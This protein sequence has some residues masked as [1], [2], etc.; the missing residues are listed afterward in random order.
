MFDEK[1]YK[2]MFSQ[3]TASDTTRRRIQNMEQE[4]MKR[5]IYPVR[6]LAGILLAVALL[7]TLSITA[8]AAV[9]GADWFEKFFRESSGNELSDSQI[10]YI[11]NNTVD[12]SQSVTHDGYT[13]SVEYAISDGYALFMKVKLTAPEGV[14]LNADDYGF[15]YQ[16]KSQFYPADG[17]NPARS[18]SWHM[19]NEDPTDNTVYFPMKWQGEGLTI[20]SKWI[21]DLTDI[22]EY[23][24][25]KD[26]FLEER[27]LAEGNFRFEITIEGTGDY[28]M[29]MLTEP[30]PYTAKIYDSDTEYHEVD[31]TLTSVVLRPLS[32]EIRIEGYNDTYRL[33]GIGQMQIFMKDGS[34]V[35]MGIRS[36]GNG[37]NAYT[38]EAPMILEEVDYLLLPDGTKITMPD[39]SG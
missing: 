11:D 23:Y 3:V 27:I 29:E 32:A 7:L 9:T 8:V 18:G 22:A 35:K 20:G 33:A 5:T 6:K 12:I 1:E 34:S 16:K 15:V 25:Q 36:G 17:S 4:T 31:V 19:V 14:V 37:E 39:F 30:L 26:G 38:M 24:E 2:A 28:E 10:A 21:L 13:V